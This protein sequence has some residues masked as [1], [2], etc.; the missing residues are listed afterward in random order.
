GCY[1]TIL[2]TLDHLGKFDR[3]ADEDYFVGYSMSSKAF[4]VY[5]IRTRRAKENLHIEFL[6]NKPIVVGTEEHIGQIHSSKEIGYCQDYILMPLWKD[7]SL[8]NYSLKNA[9]NDEPQS[10]CV[11]GNKDGNGVN[12][13]CGIDTHENSTNNINDVNTVG[14]SINT[15]NTDFD[16]GS[17]HINT[18]SPTVSTA[19]LKATHVYADDIIFDSNKKE[20]CKKFERL[21]KDRFQMSFMGE[22]IFF[23]GLQ[24]KQKDDGI[25]IDGV[26]VDVHIYRSIIR[27]LIYLTT[28]RPNIMYVICV[29]ARFQVTPKVFYL[30]TVKRIFRYLKGHPKLG[31][32]YPK[33]SPF[34]LVAYTDSDYARASLDRKSTTKG[35]Q[36][37]GSRLIS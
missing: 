6:K 26:D 30:H 9:T 4:K 20:L 24:V 18:D 32:W 2:N 16:T 13:D 11:A 7:G 5:N 23:L 25:F 3:K 15:A 12:K 1:I 35:Y 14:P 10:S 8:F 36:F 31:L 29:C 33:D 28:S 37:L 19:S 27:S 34:E 22:L 17:Q 21:I